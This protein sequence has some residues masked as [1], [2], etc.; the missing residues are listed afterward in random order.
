MVDNGEP[1][2]ESARLP[3]AKQI[4]LRDRAI[5]SVLGHVR[6]SGCKS[7]ASSHNRAG[8]GG[9][10]VF[11][12]SFICLSSISGAFHVSQSETLRLFFS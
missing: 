8:K 3:D 6:P 11:L 9:H 2:R 5:G 7:N 12:I 4:G 10:C 1:G